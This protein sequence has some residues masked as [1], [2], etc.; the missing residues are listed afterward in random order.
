MKG[1]EQV[2]L[3]SLCDKGLMFKYVGALNLSMKNH[4]EVIIWPYLACLFSA[5]P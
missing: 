3:S 4:S 2:K 5:I 1:R